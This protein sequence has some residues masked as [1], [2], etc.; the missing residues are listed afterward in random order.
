MSTF[1]ELLPLAR[2]IID[3]AAKSRLKVA[4]AESCTGGLISAML[5]EIPGSSAVFDRGMVTYSNEAKVDLLGV[6]ELR[7]CQTDRLSIR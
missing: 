5:T 7:L 3:K 4:T 2:E 6:P 1:E